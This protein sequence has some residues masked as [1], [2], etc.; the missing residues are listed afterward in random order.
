MIQSRADNRGSFPY[1]SFIEFKVKGTGV[2]VTLAN[3]WAA[4]KG[5]RSLY[6]SGGGVVYEYRKQAGKWAGKT[7]SVVI[8]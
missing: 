8:S 2:A 7:L 4:G 5:S 1:L 6:L 3:T